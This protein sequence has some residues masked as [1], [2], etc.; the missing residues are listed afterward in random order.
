MEAILNPHQCLAGHHVM[1]KYVH[2]TQG[3]KGNSN[4]S[5]KAFA[6]ILSAIVLNV[7]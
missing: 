7:N 1:R 6:V 5:R 3:K 2:T 4:N